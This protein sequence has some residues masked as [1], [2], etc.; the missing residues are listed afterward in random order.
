MQVGTDDKRDIGFECRALAC[1]LAVIPL[2]TVSKELVVLGKETIVRERVLFS[3]VTLAELLSRME[4]V[5]PRK[6]EH[7]EQLV[8]ALAVLESLGIVTV[9][10]LA[11][12]E[13][14]LEQMR[15]SV[16]SE[17]AG[18]LLHSLSKFMTILPHQRSP[19]RPNSS[20]KSL[21]AVL[22]AALEQGRINPHLLLAILLERGRKG[23]A[24]DPLRTIRV[25]SVLV[26]GERMKG[27][28]KETVY[29]HVRKPDWDS[30]ALIGSVQRVGEEDEQTARLALEEDL[31]TPAHLFAV[32][33]SNIE[34][35]S[36]LRLSI[37]TL[38]IITLTT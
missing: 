6:I 34:D 26:K 28:S 24:E 31:R 14:S 32:R 38:A 29:L 15:I 2:P 25:I 35:D 17:Q 7:R 11:A 1:A 36:D 8:A 18:F 10:K 4:A 12:R 20:V 3:S 33:P 22:E 21:H 23:A 37:W 19:I 13:Q 30:Y 9:E 16:T 5:D 27:D